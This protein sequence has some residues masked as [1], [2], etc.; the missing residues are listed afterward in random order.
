MKRWTKLYLIFFVLLFI[1]FISKYLVYKNIPQMSF[2]HPYY[3]YGG[4]GLFDNFGIS[5]S[6][7]HVQNTGAAWGIFA[8]YSKLLLFVRVFIVICLTI[9]LGYKNKDRKKDLPFLLII[10]GAIGNIIDYFLYGRVIDMF[11][12]KL[13]GYSNPVFNFADFLIT[14]GIIWLLIIFVFEKVK[15]RKL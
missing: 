11:Y 10:T 4:I 3:P 13:W 14:S 8:K 6:I 9:F 5:F 7:N 12:I 2:L 15:K 1:D